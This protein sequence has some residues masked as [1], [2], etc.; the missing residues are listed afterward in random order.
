MEVV[1]WRKIGWQGMQGGARAENKGSRRKQI[2]RD[3]TGG[4]PPRAGGEA[5]DPAHSWT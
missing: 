1:I 3:G 5:S 2:R 4:F